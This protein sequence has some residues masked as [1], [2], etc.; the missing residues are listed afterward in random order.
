MEAALAKMVLLTSLLLTGDPFQLS[1]KNSLRVL[2]FNYRLRTGSL[3]SG[4]VNGIDLIEIERLKQDI[5][6]EVRKE[7]HKAKLEII[8][9][10]LHYFFLIM[11]KFNPQSMSVSAIRMELSRK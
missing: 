4:Q 7:I 11:I 1:I 5:I 3:D 6:A 10:K 9:G 2:F 8:D